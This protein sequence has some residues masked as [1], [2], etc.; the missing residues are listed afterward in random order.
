MS[1]QVERNA[2]G[3]G[4]EAKELKVNMQHWNKREAKEFEAI[5]RRLKSNYDNA[6]DPLPDRLRELLAELNRLPTPA[7]ES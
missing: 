4:A 6:G 1:R 5:G 2:S 7:A 3:H